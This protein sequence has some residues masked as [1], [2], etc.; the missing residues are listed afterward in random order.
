MV[1]SG[2][3]IYEANNFN[4]YTCNRLLCKFVCAPRKNWSKKTTKRN[5]RRAEK[6]GFRLLLLVCDTYT[7]IE[8]ITT[9]H[10]SNAAA[11]SSWK[12]TTTKKT[13]QFIHLY[14]CVYLCRHWWV[15]TIR[16]RKRMA[17][18]SCK[19]K[20]E[21]KPAKKGKKHQNTNCGKLTV[22]YND[23]YMCITVQESA[24]A[25]RCWLIKSLLLFNFHVF[26]PYG[27]VC[28]WIWVNLKMVIHYKHIKK[29]RRAR[30]RRR[31]NGNNVHTAST[32]WGL[33]KWECK[34]YCVTYLETFSFCQC[35]CENVTHRIPIFMANL[36]FFC[37]VLFFFSSRCS[38][39][40]CCYAMRCCLFIFLSFFAVVVV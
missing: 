11:S 14:L 30:K 23:I 27:S 9:M 39:Y 18:R 20:I 2:K 16:D 6:D 22:M 35:A 5:K 29:E 25:R 1:E 31:R 26:P 7:Q 12:R 17:G 40:Y 36:F 24:S 3:R 33:G 4:M 10:T 13:F 32:H 28:K 34:C 19:V 15:K 37:F 8:H 21:H 38:C